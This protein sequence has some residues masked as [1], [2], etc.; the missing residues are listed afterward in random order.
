MTARA[1][2]PQ[3]PPGEVQ[4]HHLQIG[5]CDVDIGDPAAGRSIVG[6]MESDGLKDLLT[7]TEMR[8]AEAARTSVDDGKD[9]VAVVI[10]PELSAAIYGTDATAPVAAAVE[11]YQNPTRGIGGA[12]VQS[13][14]GRS[15]L[16]FNGAR[17]AALAAAGVATANGNAEDSGAVA[18][19]AAEAF[20]RDAE[21]GSGSLTVVSRPPDLSGGRASK[22]V[23]MIGLVLAGMMVFFMFFGASNVARTIL[24]EEQAG[25]LPRLFTTPSSRQVILGG[26]FASTFITVLAQAL[27]IIVCGRLF[28]GIDWGALE[29]V[30]LLTVVAAATAASLGLLI[31]SVVR[32][33]A[34]AGG[35]SAGV[36]LVLALL[37]GNFTGTAQSGTTYA[38]IERL[39]PNGWLLVGWNETLRGGGIGDIVWALLIPLAFAVVFFAAAVLRFRKRFA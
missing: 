21:T 33:P 32:T 26:K 8:S 2:F 29:A 7:V 30:A 4:E 37:G 18:L 19:K 24:T 15:L 31:I 6:I 1:S 25:T 10:P 13:V 22:D 3:R 5:L 38:T 16:A 28:F 27:I 11:L 23:G 17:A 39:T 9:A 12:I 14:I 34:Q 20:M 35:I 36:F